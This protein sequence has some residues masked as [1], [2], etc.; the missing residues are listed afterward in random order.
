[1]FRKSLCG[2]TLFA[3]TL[4]AVGLAQESKSLA[5]GNTIPSSF[6]GFVAVDQRFDKGSPRN[7]QDRMHCL[8]VDNALNPV[9]AVFSRSPAMNVDNQQ[10]VP[11]PE[12]KKLA[13][14]LNEMVNKPALKALRLNSFVAFL[15]LGKEYPED[16]KRDELTKQTKD[17]SAQLGTGSVPFVLA[18]SKSKETAEWGIDEKETLKIIFYREMKVLKT[19]SFSA[20][21]PLA[22]ADVAK[23]EEEVASELTPKK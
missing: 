22:D 14:K 8:V 1:M 9:I 3:L 4:S 5:V 18:Q 7:R 6:R 15:S 12:I 17:L 2:F 11:N 23:I 19:W 20:D 10:A 13:P 16:A 21:K